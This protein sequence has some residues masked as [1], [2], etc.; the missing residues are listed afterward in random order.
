MKK[1][2]VVF[3]S[4]KNSLSNSE[5]NDIAKGVFQNYKNI[6][7][8]YILFADGGEGSLASVASAISSKKIEIEVK[9]LYGYPI[10]APYLLENKK[11]YI[12][13]AKVIG[14]HLKRKDKSIFDASSD[15]VATLI[16]E[17]IS[18]GAEDIYLF[19]GGTATVDIGTGWMREAGTDFIDKNNQLIQT[20]NP[21]GHFHKVNIKGWEAFDDNIAIHIISDVQNS[22]LGNMGGIRIY[23]PQKG[24][25]AS[26][27]EQVEEQ[28]SLWINLLNQYFDNSPPI[29]GNEQYSGAAG[30]IGIPFFY[31]RD[32]S[33]QLGFDYFKNLLN[34][35]QHI[36][37]TDIII[38]G[39]GRID[40]QTSM[41]K[42][43]GQLA[44]LCKKHNKT[45]FAICGANAYQG[46]LFDKILVLGDGKLTKEDAITHASELFKTQITKIAE[47]LSE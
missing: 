15:G 20:G 33:F 4:F 36:Q 34:I 3:D 37:N 30:G 13:V 23:G 2:L 9:D 41:G 19:L 16:K 39:E 11:A 27:T 26:Q 40:A 42:G 25:L 7:V 10:I 35:E 29:K 24:L 28:T 12:E 45:V 8:Q 17:A 14:A 44:Q 22:I 1:A 32:Q 21:L 5:I 47:F 43:V 6:Q 31:F 38:T 46:N 18:Q